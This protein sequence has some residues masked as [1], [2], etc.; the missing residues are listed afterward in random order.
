M[1][2]LTLFARAALTLSTRQC[3]VCQHRDRA[4]AMFHLPGYGWF[5]NQTEARRWWGQL[6]ASVMARERARRRWGIA[7]RVARGVGVAA[8]LVMLVWLVML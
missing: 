3:Q 7:L 6:P 5:C 1:P 2:I 8:S 4:Q